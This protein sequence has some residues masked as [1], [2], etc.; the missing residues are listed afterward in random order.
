[1]KG[2]PLLMNF[3]NHGQTFFEVILLYTCKYVKFRKSYKK[4]K[5]QFPKDET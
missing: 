4:M 5:T 3:R 1:M 2:N